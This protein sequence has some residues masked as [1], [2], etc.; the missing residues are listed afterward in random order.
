MHRWQC[1]LA[2]KNAWNAMASNHGGVMPDVLDAFPYAQTFASK[3]NPRQPFSTVVE[4]KSVGNFAI[5]GY[6]TDCRGSAGEQKMGL[7]EEMTCWIL[8]PPETIKKRL[9]IL[10][11]FPKKTMPLKPS[12][13]CKASGFDAG[14]NR[15]VPRT[16]PWG[17]RFGKSPASKSNIDK[18]QQLAACQL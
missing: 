8:G 15:R 14:P 16:C 6:R 3:G 12:A 10:S 18:F 2:L 7:N 5:Q 4:A 9:A 11:W 1:S 17:H 13:C